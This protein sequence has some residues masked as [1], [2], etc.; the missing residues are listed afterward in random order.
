ML[1]NNESILKCTKYNFWIKKV[2]VEAYWKT[3][4]KKKCVFFSKIIETGLKGKICSTIRVR[5]TY[6]MHDIY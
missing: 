2:L 5:A 1:G 4:L 6:D 3:N